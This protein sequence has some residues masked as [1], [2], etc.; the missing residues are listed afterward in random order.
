MPH[1]STL[2]QSTAHYYAAH[3]P[4][5]PSKL[6]ADITEQF[7]LSDSGLGTGILLDLGC[8]TGEM[9]LPLAKYF[10]RIYAWDPDPDMLIQLRRNAR[11]M[12]TPRQLRKITTRQKSSDDLTKV[13]KATFGRNNSGLRLVT[14][15]QSFHWM[16][17][18]AVLRQLRALIQ[19]DGGLVIISGVTDPLQNPQDPLSAQKDQLIKDTVQKYLGPERRAGVSHY[20]PTPESY[21]DL[22]VAAGFGTVREEIYSYVLPR[23]IDEVVGYVFSLSWASKAQLGDRAPSFEAELRAALSA[24]APRGRFEDRVMF[25]SFTAKA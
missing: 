25:S 8:G 15:G 5:Y 9:A 16:D 1:D 19:P 2:F 11:A 24:L 4:A 22:L 18:P 10:E 7:S 21:R 6:F 14:M 13:G 12:L 20:Q 17:K 23:S 3:R